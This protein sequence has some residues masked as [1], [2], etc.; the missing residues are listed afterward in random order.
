[1]Y[2]NDVEVGVLAWLGIVEIIV[3]ADIKYIINYYKI[4]RAKK[5]GN[6]D[7]EHSSEHNYTF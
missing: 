5:L 6:S 7:N 3:L 1:M 2:L 4:I